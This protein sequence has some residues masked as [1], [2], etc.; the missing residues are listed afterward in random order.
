[1]AVPRLSALLVARRLLG[2]QRGL[3]PATARCGGCGGCTCGCRGLATSARRD[4]DRFFTKKHEWVLVDGAS[5]RAGGVIASAGTVGISKYAADALGEG[6]YAQ[7]PEP[8]DTVASG[9]VSCL[10]IGQG[11]SIALQMCPDVPTP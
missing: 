11:A 1:M 9:E 6:V 8:G 2:G 7:L 5:G 10:H 4:A 3:A